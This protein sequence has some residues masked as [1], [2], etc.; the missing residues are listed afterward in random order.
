VGIPEQS[1]PSGL[2]DGWLE[3]WKKDDKYNWIYSDFEDLDGVDGQGINSQPESIFANH[4]FNKIANVYQDPSYGIQYKSEEDFEEKAIVASAYHRQF[5]LN[6][7]NFDI[8]GDGNPDDLNG[9]GKIEHFARVYMF[10]ATTN[11][12]LGIMNFIERNH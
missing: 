1:N 6:E 11:L 12:D 3:S 4:R 9:D 5:T 2:R 8:N 7:Y 10:F